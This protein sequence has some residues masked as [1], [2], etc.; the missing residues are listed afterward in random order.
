MYKIAAVF[1]L[2]FWAS[3]AF[4]PDALAKPFSARRVPAAAE[5]V[6]HV[7]LDGL[8]R[9]RLW[10]VLDAKSGLAE[11]EKEIRVDAPKGWSKADIDLAVQVIDSAQSITF[12]VDASETGALLVQVPGAAKVEA[13]LGRK[14]KESK[15]KR[16]VTVYRL[17]EDDGDGA[18]AARQGDTLI[19]AEKHQAVVESALVLQ[20]KGKSLPPG[21]LGAGSAKGD[22]FFI[23]GFRGQIMEALRESA[24]ARTLG[25]DIRSVSMHGGETS[26][27]VFLTAR[28]ETSSS[29]TAQ[30]LASVAQ[31]LS[32]LVSLAGDEPELAELVRGLTVTHKGTTVTARLEIA[33]GTLKKLIAK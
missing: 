7:D 12:W 1:S 25:A 20:G 14:A 17:A 13:L 27:A 8:R 2:F 18:F 23:A 22:I 21:R 19:L 9:S 24:Q 6:I 32:A 33:H 3:L 15:K 10:T 11:L 29:A 31:G 28:V 5:G 26:K 16:G 30:K 4:A